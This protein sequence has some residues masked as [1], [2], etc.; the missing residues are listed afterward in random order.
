[1]QVAKEQFLTEGTMY[2]EGAGT[3]VFLV[4]REK[5]FTACFQTSFRKEFN[6][7]PRAVKDVASIIWS[8]II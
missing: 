3:S 4:D 1:M 2:H 7:D 6:W 8:G 5:N